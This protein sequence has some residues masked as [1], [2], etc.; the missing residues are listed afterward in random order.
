MEAVEIIARALV[1]ARGFRWGN[2]TN[3]E[4][5]DR[6]AEA[7]AVAK[8]LED[9]GMCVVANAQ[10]V[11]RADADRLVAHIVDADRARMIQAATPTPSRTEEGDGW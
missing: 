11:S 4:I 6:S 9:A 1:E 2:C 8:A 3:S 5:M 7:L 10:W